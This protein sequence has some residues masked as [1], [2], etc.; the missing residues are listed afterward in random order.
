VN[1]QLRDLLERRAP[2]AT[3]EP[4]VM[5]LLAGA[6]DDAHLRGLRKLVL[7]CELLPLRGLADYEEAAAVYRAC[8]RSGST[9]RRLV[10]CLIAVVAINSRTVLLH[11]DADFD[12]IANHS[13]LRLVTDA[14]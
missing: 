12:L 7:G 3:T 1:A 2:L 9:V 10:D 14:R 4:I 6:R 11:A 5:E 8:R 13:E